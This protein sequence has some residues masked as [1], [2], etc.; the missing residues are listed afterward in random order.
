MNFSID[1]CENFYEFTCGN[2]KHSSSQEEHS[3][4]S[5]G[6]LINSDQFSKINDKV[7]KATQGEFLIL[8]VLMNILQDFIHKF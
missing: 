1:P 3:S 8:Q 2:W 4:V 7:I 5:S 6:M